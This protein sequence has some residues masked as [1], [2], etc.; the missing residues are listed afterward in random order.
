MDFGRNPKKIL[1]EFDLICIKIYEKHS[2][3]VLL[4]VSLTLLPDTVT[5]FP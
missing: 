4:F 3:V 1:L 2:T 5:I